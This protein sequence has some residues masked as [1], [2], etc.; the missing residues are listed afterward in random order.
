MI[1]RLV[2]IICGC[3][4]KRVLASSSLGSPVP[5]PSTHLSGSRRL[6][7]D[8]PGAASLQGRGV[9]VAV[10]DSGVNPDHPHVGSVAGGVRITL[11][12]AEA[13]DHVD[14]LGHGTAVFAAIQEKAP[15]ADLFAVRVFDD[16]LRTS[17]RAL[18][19]A[20]DWAA[21]RRVRVLNLSLGTLREEHA[22]DLE[23][24]VERLAAVG[25][26]VVAAAEDRGRRW[27]PGCL[28]IAVGVLADR[29]C[30]RHCVTV[31]TA[32]GGGERGDG[33]ED[34]SR[35]GRG[36]RREDSREDGRRDRRRDGRGDQRRDERRR[37]DIVS[38]SP[39]PRP[40]AGVPVE[41]N[42]QGVSFAVANAC[43]VLARVLEGAEGPLTAE[44]CRH[45][46]ASHGGGLGAAPRAWTGGPLATIAAPTPEGHGTE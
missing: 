9:S 30:P 15:A 29:R 32:G 37:L 13:E 14:R 17:S 46:L 26:V 7:L 38:A 22:A 39:Y 11:S 2:Q 12:G 27:W 33:R 5:R 40:I 20:I 6:C 10:V 44:R 35:D 28:P 3:D 8:S 1:R 23:A 18:V 19:A 24:A 45:L 16:R 31:G 34:G 21:E 4:R 36:D 25:G 41:R 43:G 42:L